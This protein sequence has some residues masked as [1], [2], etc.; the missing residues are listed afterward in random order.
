MPRPTTSVDHSD[1]TFAQALDAAVLDGLDDSDGPDDVLLDLGDARRTG[2]R[3][4]R[5]ARKERIQRVD[6]SLLHSAKRGSL[7]RLAAQ[8]EVMHDAGTMVAIERGPDPRTTLKYMPLA[9]RLGMR[10]I[11]AGKR[12]EK[13]VASHKVRRLLERATVREGLSFGSSIVGGNTR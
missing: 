13:F 2:Q 12:K 5:S 10:I 8:F 1:L 3:G 6:C 11:W 4:D 9:I 7:I